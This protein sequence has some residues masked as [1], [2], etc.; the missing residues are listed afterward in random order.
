MDMG[1]LHG[2]AWCVVALV[3]AESGA[4]GATAAGRYFNVNSVGMNLLGG[5]R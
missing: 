5:G 3:V 1:S 2:T 4:A